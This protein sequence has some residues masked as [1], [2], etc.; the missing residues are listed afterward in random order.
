MSFSQY[1]WDKY[2]SMVE[3]AYNNSWQKSINIRLVLLNHGQHPLASINR[4]INGSQV[5]AAIFFFALTISNVMSSFSCLFSH[6][7]VCN[8]KIFL[9]LFL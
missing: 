4:K 2:L 9:N 6:I 3:F 8:I 5:P 1:D 7:V